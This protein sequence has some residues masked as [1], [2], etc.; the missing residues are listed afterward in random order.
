MICSRYIL[1]WPH[2]WWHDQA[3]VFA[4]PNFLE[5]VRDRAIG[6][7][8]PLS[9]NLRGGGYSPH[10]WHTT[11]HFD[12]VAVE[13]HRVAAFLRTISLLPHMFFSVPPCGS[14]GTTY[15][16]ELAHVQGCPV[17]YDRMHRAMLLIA[18]Y[19]LREVSAIATEIGRCNRRLYMESGFPNSQ[20]VLLSWSGLIHQGSVPMPLALLSCPPCP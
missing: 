10:V 19:A 20:R 13:Q 16:N 12:A 11:C 14:R 5:Y 2:V 9:P 17:L 3:L 15:G 1:D 8:S 7:H 6:A 18:V 4:Y